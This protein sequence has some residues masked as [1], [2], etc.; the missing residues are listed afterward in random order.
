MTCTLWHEWLKT[1][2][3]WWISRK[4]WIRPGAKRLGGETGVCK[5]Y[6]GPIGDLS[7]LTATARVYSLH[8]ELPQI[9]YCVCLCAVRLQKMKT[10]RERQIRSKAQKRARSRSVRSCSMESKI[11]RHGLFHYCSDFKYDWVID[12]LS[13]AI[14]SC[15]FGSIWTSETVKWYLTWGGEVG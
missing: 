6:I 11:R 3:R 15:D 12:Y 1:S 8:W 5:Y 7:L 4:R 10:E 13:A 14:K 2:K 9:V